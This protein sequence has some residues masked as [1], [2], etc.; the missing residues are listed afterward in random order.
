M[1]TRKGVILIAAVTS[2]YSYI[3]A[4][5]IIILGKDVP[6]SDSGLILIYY[7]QSNQFS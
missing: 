3:K 2:G 6:G 5:I 4:L 1:R 7:L